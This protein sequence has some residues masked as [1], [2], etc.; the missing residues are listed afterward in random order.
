MKLTRLGH[1][2]V[3]IEGSKT[4]IIDPFLTNN[5]AASTTLDTLSKVDIVLVTHDHF[6]HFGDAV[7]I[8]KRD[9]ATLVVLHELTTLD[10]VTE[11]GIEAVGMNIGGTYKIDDVAISLTPAMHS[12]EHGY[13]TG[14]VVKMDGKTIYHAGDT[15]LFGDMALIPQLHGPLDVAFLPIGGHYTM[16]VLGAALALGLLKPM[17]T[18]PIHYNTWPLIQADP[19]E[20]VT[21]RGSC[22]VVVLEP[23]ESHELGS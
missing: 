12:A 13:P 5:P 15:A 10:A 11:A 20:L 6:D 4:I 19:D 18:I 8:A 17:V 7:A 14:Y 16:D 9:N 3:L 21:R 1:A 22:Q 2:C 23:G